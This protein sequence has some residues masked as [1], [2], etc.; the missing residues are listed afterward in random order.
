MSKHRKRKRTGNYM[1]KR[2]RD[3]AEASGAITAPVSLYVDG[4]K[5]AECVS[6][7][8]KISNGGSR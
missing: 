7:S 1:R 2:L 6:G 3:R 8:F 4:V 5:V